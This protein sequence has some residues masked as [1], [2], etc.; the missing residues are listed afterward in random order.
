MRII[1]GS[2]VNIVVDDN[3]PPS[4]IMTVL[5]Q[6]YKELENSEYNITTENGEQVMRVTLK[7]GTKAA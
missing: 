7:S 3:T 1:Y 2:E 5:K 4:E 6:S